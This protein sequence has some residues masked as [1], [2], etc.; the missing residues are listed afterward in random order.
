MK[1]QQDTLMAGGSVL[2]GQESR[3]AAVVPHSQ[4]ITVLL[5]SVKV[6]D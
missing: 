5:C 6:K 4:R 3:A 1:M 2:A